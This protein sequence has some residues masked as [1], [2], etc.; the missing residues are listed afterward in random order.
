M[1]AICLIMITFFLVKIFNFI[2]T[3]HSGSLRMCQFSSD[4]SQIYPSDRQVLW[5]ATHPAD[6]VA[7]HNIHE[8]TCKQALKAIPLK[9]ASHECG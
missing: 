4:L 6:S 2:V 3:S 1:Y 8:L 9:F 5:L 7:Y